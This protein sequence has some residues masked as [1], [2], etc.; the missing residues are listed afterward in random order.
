MRFLVLGAGALGGFYGARLLQGGADVTFLVRPGRAAQLQR[1]GLIVKS[2]EGDTRTPVKTVL[3]GQIETV[4]DVILLSCKA[5]DLESAMTAIAPAVGS[6]TAILPVLN[7]VR[8]IDVLKERFGADKVLGGTSLTNAVLMP[9]GTIQRTPVRI[10]I[11]DALGELDGRSSARCEAIQAAYAAGGMTTDLRTDIVA[12][13]WE[14]FVGFSCNA[15]IATLM[16]SRAGTIARSEA[17]ASFVSAVIDEVTRIATAEGYP[18]PGQLAGI[19]K[20]LF[21]Q[22]TSAYGPS[23]LVDMEAGR[24][25]EGEHTIGDLVDRAT[26]RGVAAPIL[27]AARCNLQAYELNRELRRGKPI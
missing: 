20:G 25:T 10:A 19:I 14:K 1:D 18:P 6:Q 16:R 24:T 26:K 8:H 17:G 13:M 22:P 23:M 21:S 5:Y 7:G 3:Q 11:N 2:Q 12:A 27:T 4:F 9:D 15:A